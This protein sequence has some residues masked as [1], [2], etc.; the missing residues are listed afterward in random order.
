MKTSTWAHGLCLLSLIPSTRG[1]IEERPK[2]SIAKPTLKT[3]T[4]DYLKE[5]SSGL[6]RIPA[7]TTL[8]PNKVQ[9]C[10]RAIRRKK[11]G[12]EEGANP[13]EYWFDNRIHVFGNTGFSGAFHAAVAPLSTK[14]IDVLAYHGV[15]LRA[16]VRRCCG[17][18]SCL[19]GRHTR[20]Y[21]SVFRSRPSHLSGMAYLRT[22][23][24]LGRNRT[25]Q[26][27]RQGQ[28]SGCRS[29]LWSRH[30]HTSSQ[31]RIS[32]CYLCHWC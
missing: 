2:F 8:P 25:I 30:V 19:P 4:S 11:W 18:W 3:V 29:L 9:D 10:R 24:D 13:D 1:F 20:T 15:D 12:V 17:V 22:T 28:G 21:L 31:C 16:Q 23:I 14:L 6:K 26:D 5:K 32:R 7:D 27:C